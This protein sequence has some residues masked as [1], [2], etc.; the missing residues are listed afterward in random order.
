MSKINRGEIYYIAPYYYT[1]GSEQKGDRPAVIV[2][3]QKNNEYSSTVEVVYL[4]TKPKADLPTHVTVR[5][6]GRQSIALCEQIS[7]VA[8]ERIGQFCG[9][10]TTQEIT[11]IETAMLISL[12]ISFEPAKER[13]VEV[14]KEVPVEVVKEVVKEVPIASDNSDCIALKAQLEIV[15]SMYSDLLSKTLTNSIHKE[16]T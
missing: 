12:G 3:N 1:T 13:V 2:S 6:T 10:C 5:G 14:V 9:V 8:V 4:T 7:T 15:Q 16:R 11:S